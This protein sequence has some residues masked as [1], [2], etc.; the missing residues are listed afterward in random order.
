MGGPITPEQWQI[1]DEIADKYCRHESTEPSLRLTTRQNVQFHWVKKKDLVNLVRELAEKGLLSLNGCGDNVRNVMACPLARFSD[2]YNANHLATEIGDYFQLSTEPFI[3][4]FEIDPTYL[5]TDEQDKAKEKFSYGPQLLNR[6][7][8][9][10]L[11]AVHR[12]LSSGNLVPDNCVELRTND[13]GIAPIWEGEKV[14]AYQFYIGG[15]Q[16]QKNGKLSTAVLAEP[17][18]I[19]TPEQVM[20]VMD[21]IV[22][23]HQEWGDRQNR[24][25]ARLKY[26]VKKQGVAWFRQKVEGRLGYKLEDAN[27]EHDYGARMLHHGWNLQPSDGKWSFT[28]YIENGR[29]ID[30]GENGSLKTMC[31]EV[32]EKF[33]VDTI[34]TPNQD[35]MFCGL[36]ESQKDE[37]EAA[38]GSYGFGKRRGKEYS[39]LRKLSGACVGRDTCRLTY[40]DSE[41][42]EP[43]LIDKL[44]DLGWGESAE[45]IGITGCER[46]CFRPSTKSIGLIGTG[47]NRYQVR[48]MGSEDGSTQGEPL[49][50]N[51]K[52]YLRSVP[53]EKVA[54]VIDS[55]FR[56]H[57]DNAQAGEKLGPFHQRVGM[58]AVIAHLRVDEA[59]SELMSREDKT[60]DLFPVV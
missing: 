12:D 34:I 45:S 51:E 41:K 40:T 8:K 28:A 19:A 49:V 17:L 57:K 32:I 60:A 27:S 30:G 11:S 35:L 54:V 56:F 15:G 44:E 46:Q 58:S 9:I 33:S 6:K 4:I 55:I 20:P 38:L 47:L 21:A 14:N 1:L 16:G 18:C 29:I 24:H 23:T 59:T 50:E 3:K 53:R 5:R 42:F 2:I 10:A 7:F 48:I 39:E 52:M 22:A 25:W 36:E 31:R 43:E 13:V 26:V 37:F